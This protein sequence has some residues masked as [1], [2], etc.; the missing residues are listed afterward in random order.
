MARKTHNSHR[1]IHSSF[2]VNPSTTAASTQFCKDVLLVNNH[3]MPKVAKKPGDTPQQLAQLPETEN[4]VK[5]IVPLFQ[6]QP[7]IDKD[8][9]KLDY[10]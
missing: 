3:T 10:W 6:T 5:A 2:T 7:L 9:T 8:A 4:E 1:P